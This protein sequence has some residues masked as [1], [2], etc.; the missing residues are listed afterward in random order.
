VRDKMTS[1]AQN[2]MESVQ[3]ANAVRAS[4]TSSADRDRLVPVLVFVV[5][6]AYLTAFRHYSSLEPDEGIV[7]QGAERI[8]HGEV[9]YRDF[10]SFYTPGS[11]YLVGFL[12]RFLG[13]SLV[14]ARL[15]L[16][17]AGAACSVITYLLA[18][19]VTSR[20]IALFTASLTTA[21]GFAYRFL[22]LHNWY[23]TLL[24]CLAVYSAVRLLESHK[25]SWAFAT[26]WFASLTILFEQSKGVGLCLGLALGFA[27]L[28]FAGREPIFRRSEVASILVG[29]LLPLLGVVAYFGAEHSL[30]AML[31]DWIWPLRHYTQANRVP[32]GWQNWSDNA[33]QTIFYSGPMGIRILKILAVS[34]GFFVPVLPLVAVGLFGYWTKQVRDHKASPDHR[35]YYVLISAVLSGLLL[36]IVIVRADIIHFMYLVP[37]WYVLLAWVLGSHH[38]VSRALTKIRPYLIAYVSVAFGMMALAVLLTVTGARNRID[39]RRG[40]ITTGEKDTVIDY[41][42]AHLAPGQ[43][44]LVYPYLPLYNYLTA[45]RSP[46]PYDYFQAGMNTP[47]QAQQII[48]SVQSHQVRVVLFEPWF[49]N[50]F[51]NSWPGTPLATIAKDPVADYVVH[52]YHVCRLLNSASDG[53][54]EYMV[55]REG[56]CP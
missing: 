20:G 28:R 14:V 5:S 37:L 9:P 43:E 18:R 52:N 22:V 15:S 34:P 30:A 41:V 1:I 23:S 54:F 35:R 42:Q 44:L 53:R 16:A 2:E 51:S 32:Y 45:T 55:G 40:L 31:Q 6:L 36:S 13:D 50:K 47:Q 49:S 10:F 56:S 46:S 12:F 29:F 39:T 38:L 11:F 19:R 24:G 48:A 4:M 7:L 33:R 27:S 21:A 17:V 3:S 26:G 8:L 25:A